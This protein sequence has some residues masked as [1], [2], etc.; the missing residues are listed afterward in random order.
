MSYG[1]SMN[2]HGVCCGVNA[3]TLLSVSRKV[4]NNRERFRNKQTD[5]LSQLSYVLLD[6]AHVSPA[7]A[8]RFTAAADEYEGR[9]CFDAVFHR[10]VLVL[11]HVN[12]GEGN[13]ALP[14][15]EAVDVGSNLL[16]R[17][18]PHSVEVQHNLA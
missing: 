5:D 2:N 13:A 8:T 7:H 6:S 16:A 18:A 17:A 3:N 11:V 15:R 9:H 12:L 14:L 1:A 10:D 4:P